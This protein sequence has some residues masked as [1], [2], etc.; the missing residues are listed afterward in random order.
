[1]DCA[2]IDSREVFEK[3]ASEE[4]SLLTTEGLR[5]VVPRRKNAAHGPLR[6]S[7]VG[8]TGDTGDSAV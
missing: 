2:R 1:M 6:F 4:R 7:L 5:M 8:D 3:E